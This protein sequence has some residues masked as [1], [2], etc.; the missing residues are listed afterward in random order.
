M[1]AGR[2][3]S[4]CVDERAGGLIEDE[5]EELDVD[6]LFR[7]IDVA[8]HRTERLTVVLDQRS[9]AAPPWGVR[10][11]RGRRPNPT[12][13]KATSPRRGTKT[14]PWR[15][16]R[17][18]AW[19]CCRQGQHPFARSAPERWPI[20]TA[21]DLL[22]ASSPL[23]ALPR[24]VEVELRKVVDSI[25]AESGSPHAPSAGLRALDRH[26]RSL[27]LYLVRRLDHFEDGALLFVVTARRLHSSFPGSV[28]DG[29]ENAVP[30]LRAARAV[31]TAAGRGDPP[32]AE[33]PALHRALRMIAVDDGERD[34]DADDRDW[35]VRQLISYRE[36]LDAE[37]VRLVAW[38][39]LEL[40]VIARVLKMSAPSVRERYLRVRAELADQLRQSG[41][42]ARPSPPHVRAS[43]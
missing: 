15:V 20:P 42:L 23:I 5:D 16:S 22:T 18:L 33:A 39:R 7:R 14:M 24:T 19:R 17:D 37:I 31:L 3:A 27:L 36:P 35:R 43:T 29:A 4:Q 38:E 25:R 26:R 40:D 11:A 12:R 10:R 32:G 41:D 28:H 30:V 8:D 1:T 2:R 34:L 9:G 13:E 6:E 21:D